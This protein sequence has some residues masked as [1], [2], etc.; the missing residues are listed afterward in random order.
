MPKY[1]LPGLERVDPER[2]W[3]AWEPG[4]DQPWNLKWAGHLYRRV[5]FGA[6]LAELHAAL[7]QGFPAT[8]ARLLRGGPQAEERDRFLTSLGKTI[9][10][11]DDADSLRA[12]WVYCLL[13]TLH[14]LREKM[15]LFWHNQFATSIAKVQQVPLMYQ[16]N[17][18]FRRHALG[19]FGPL[20]LEVSRDPAMLIWLDS[21]SNVRG[22]AN[23]NY[24]R[25]L[26]E[27]FTLGV[28]HYTE[29]DVREA[30]RAFTGW[31]TDGET[32]EFNPL[33]HDDG[34]KTVLGQEGNWNGDDVV[35]ILLEQPEAARFLV[36]A[37]YRFYIS[38]TAE[39]PAALLQP[40]AD[41]FRK[42][43]YD[44]GELVTTLLSSRLFFSEHAYRQRVKSPVE[45]TL[46]SVRALVEG[47]VPP[48]VLAHR[49]EAMGQ[50]LFAP[51]NVKGWEG[52]RSWLNTATVLARHNFAQKIA[53]GRAAVMD[54]EAP[55]GAPGQVPPPQAQPQQ[56]D[57]AEPALDPATIVRRE[58]ASDPESIV[59]LLL[60]LLLQG[61]ASPPARDKLIAFVAHGNPQDKALDQRVR[62]ATHAIMTMPEYQLA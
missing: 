1:T 30:A 23:E 53:L 20:L 27:L 54:V 31:H 41:D 16:Q 2:A 13:N 3:Q 49:L 19:K 15:T 24:A 8:L 47:P 6:T 34:A 21:N 4:A 22:K 28:G 58:K 57:P 50:Q 29:Q 44:V 61:D 35:R 36:R 14:P 45:F 17:L 5:G 51:P 32:F 42:S 56:E 39:P 59:A 9:A 38:E 40:L 60:D 33:V 10:A 12:W 26:M 11:K 7:R 52:G 62:E 25:E 18:L 43:D 55:E 37:L 46:G 48:L